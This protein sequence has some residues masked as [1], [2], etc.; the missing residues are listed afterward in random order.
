MRGGPTCDYGWVERLDAYCFTA[1]IGLGS[2]EVIRRLGGDPGASA[3]LTFEEC[4]WTVDAPQWAQVGEVGR[5]VLIAEHN[6][7]RGEEAAGNLSARGRTACFCRDVSA[8]MR[9]SHAVDG[10]VLAAFD[11]LLDP[12]P[13]EGADPACLDGLL[14]GLPFGLDAAEASAMALLERVTGVRVTAEW[15]NRPQRAVQLPPLTPVS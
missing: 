14:A 2:D 12:A 3:S 9:F 5:G 15:L 10:V 6:G 8:A 4:F 11:P 1:V 7:W 13:A